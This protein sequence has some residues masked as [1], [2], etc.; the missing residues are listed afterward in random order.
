M[1][2]Y[3]QRDAWGGARFARM[4]RND[5]EFWVEWVFSPGEAPDDEGIV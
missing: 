3:P 5:R 2:K 4:V 1:S